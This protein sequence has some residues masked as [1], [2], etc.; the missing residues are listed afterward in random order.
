MAFREAARRSAVSACLFDLPTV[1][2]SNSQALHAME[3][4]AC[5]A[6]ITLRV[7]EV[8]G[9]SWGKLKEK[10]CLLLNSVAMNILIAKPL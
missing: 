6:T 8:T 3:T 4:V 5:I 7:I 1:P 10:R 9:R 2:P